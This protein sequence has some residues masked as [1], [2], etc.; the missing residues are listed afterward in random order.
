MATQTAQTTRGN[1]GV[2]TAAPRHPARYTAALLPIMAAHLGGCTR[3]LDPFAGVGGIYRLAPLL[4][5][6]VAL[7]GVE[8]EPEWAAAD[9]RTVTGDARRLVEL[10]GGGAFDGVCTS[11][12]YGNR[13]ADHH[14]ARDASRRNTYRHA[15]ER[16]LTAGNSGA[17]QWGRAYQDFHAQVWAQVYA[18]LRPGGV[19][20]L[21]VKD[22]YR[23]GALVGVTAWHAAA[24]AECGFTLVAQEAVRCSG[25]RFGANRARVDYE[26]VLVFRR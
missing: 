3:I 23:A 4:A 11:P 8:L 22:H 12:T 20:V 6:G 13:M 15:L 24:A 26:S 2:L 1:G 21:N 16:A 7:V 10:F 19:F 18:V 9:A 14:E 17:L 25:L 5:P